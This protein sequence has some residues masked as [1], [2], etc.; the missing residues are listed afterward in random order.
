MWPVCFD[1]DSTPSEIAMP[2]VGLC[3]FTAFPL[4]ALALATLALAALAAMPFAALSP[5]APSPFRFVFIALTP[6]ALALSTFSLTVQPFR[7]LSPDALS[8][9]EPIDFERLTSA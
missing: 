2:R 4:T 7:A 9:R 5:T 8:V 1:A 6:T 3:P